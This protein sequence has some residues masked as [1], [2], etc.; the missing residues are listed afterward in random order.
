MSQKKSTIE[1]KYLLERNTGVFKFV[2]HDKN[3]IKIAVNHGWLPG[4]RYTH[5]RNIKIFNRL[6][7]LDIDWKRYDFK[8]HLK[9]T[10]MTRP[11]MTVARDV[12]DKRELNKIIDEAFSLQKYAKIV[13]IVPKDR[14]LSCH[15]NNIIPKNFL[16]GFSVTSSYGETNIEPKYFNRPVHLLGGRPEVQRNLANLMPVVSFDNNRFT[17]DAIYGDY[18]DG[19]I[20]RP[21]PNGGYIS[22]I[23]D[24][25]ININRLWEDYKPPYW[26]YST[27]FKLET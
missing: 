8:R 25:I 23:R 6:G 2:N 14:K 26:E 3:V 4:A 19:Q 27:N 12:L 24:S 16:L 13:I 11:F 1:I 5:L 7:F 20:F 15:I 17:L 21:H 22:C 9:A 18:F 10:K